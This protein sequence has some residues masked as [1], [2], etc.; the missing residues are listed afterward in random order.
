MSNNSGG[1]RRVFDEAFRR[2]AV[3]ILATSDRTIRQVV[4]DLG[5]GVSSLGKWKRQYDEA[6]LLAGSPDDV[7]EELARLRRENEL[8]R[9]ERDPL[10][11][12]TTFFAKETCRYVVTRGTS[13][14]AS[15]NWEEGDV[16][17][18]GSTRDPA[19]ASDTSARRRNGSRRQNLSLFWCRP[20][21]LLSLAPN[22]CRAWRGWI[23][24]RAVDPKVACEQDITRARREGFISSSQIPSRPDADCLV[25]GALPRHQN[26]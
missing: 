19:Q 14:L 16:H 15:Q 5:V 13:S 25:S 21:Q 18:Q 9:A 22:L 12:A 6:A 17:D 7:D 11:K 23:D 20:I 26:L 8:L 4:G 24:Q 1:K 10:K 2:E 3:Q